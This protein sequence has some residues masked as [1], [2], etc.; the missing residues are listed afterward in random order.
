[1][2][3]MSGAE[4]KDSLQRM[5]PEVYALGERVEDITEHP[6]LKPAFE[7]RA[8]FHDFMRNPRYKEHVTSISTLVPG[9]EIPNFV[10]LFDS[11]EYLVERFVSGRWL[12][13]LFPARWGGWADSVNAVWATTY[14][15]D[16]KYGANYHE[17]F[18][19]FLKYV[20]KN[21]LSCTMGQT[22][23]KGDRSKRPIEQ[24]DPDMF[25]HKVETRKDGIVVRGAKAHQTRS[26]H[27]HE[28]LCMP[29]RRMREDEKDYS[30]GFAIPTNTK[31]VI[32]ICAR[33]PSDLRRLDGMDIDS[34]MPQFGG[35][36]AL[37]IFDNVFVPWDRVF[38]NGEWDFTTEMMET[39]A[40]FHRVTYA[41]KCALGD[42][43][44]GAAAQIAEYNGVA[45][46]SHIRSKLADMVVLNETIYCCG[47][48]AA[49]QGV[50]T[51]SGMWH[52][53]PVLSNVVKHNVTKNM[54][55]I[56]RLAEDIAGGLLSTQPSEKDWMN[57]K[58]RPYIEKY[59]KGVDG[60]PTEHRMRMFK[61]L[62]CFTYGQVSTYARFESMHGAGSPEA[63]K[64]FINR[65]YDFE[66]LKK[67][68]RVVCGIEK[69]EEGFIHQ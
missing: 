23:V 24:S 50:K 6:F 22:D 55:E 36:E 52:D 44:I 58:T 38:L 57:P 32:Q 20:H 49:S 39:F 12:M 34:G 2:S 8:R 10:R 33:Q 25:V 21:G 45:K 43:L 5:K 66:S 40:N 54:Y 31:G 18:K 11:A 69:E 13:R 67:L 68:A 42:I 62:E 37:V 61:L 26:I 17:T 7:T 53:D 48:A 63:Q 1:M 65:M 14:D 35:T 64:V 16:K 28:I 30:V 59:L 4:L 9:E 29:T 3:V 47:L 15:C 19:E 51:P 27:S 41:L 46:A 56:G 60:V